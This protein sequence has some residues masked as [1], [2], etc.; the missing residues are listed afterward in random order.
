MVWLIVSLTCALYKR[1]RTVLEELSNMWQVLGM[2]AVVFQRSSLRQ[3][4]LMVRN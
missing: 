3:W 1:E 2:E 4:Y